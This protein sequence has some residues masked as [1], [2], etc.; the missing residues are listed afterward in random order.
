[1]KSTGSPSSRR[2]RLWLLLKN[3]WLLPLLRLVI[4]PVPVILNRFAA[5]LFVLIFGMAFLGTWFREQDHY[6]LLP[7]ENRWPF[8]DCRFAECFCESIHL[9]QA[10]LGVG[11]FP[12]SKLACHAYL[13]PFSEEL[14]R[15]FEQ[16]LHVIF[17]NTR[18]H[19]YTLYILSFALS[20][21]L[22]LLGL[23][24]ML[25]VV[26]DFGDWWVRSCGDH[27]EVEPLLFGHGKRLS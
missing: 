3:M 5:V 13:V 25:A 6:H 24:F 19:L 21:L 26:N 22:A 18:T 4:L 10:D 9:V 1:M 12:G 27:D 11:N 20:F 15:I 8:D 7:F 16:G 17:R 2:R 23:V 14:P